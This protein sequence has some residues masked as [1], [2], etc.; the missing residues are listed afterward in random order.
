MKSYIAKV[1]FASDDKRRVLETLALNRDAWNECSKKLFV[2][3]T[4]SLK[5][6]HRLNY[7]T[8]RAK[9]QALP[10]QIVIKAEQD[11]L[12]AYRSIR[13]N[14]VKLNA[15]AIKKRLAYRLDAR[16]YSLRNDTVRLTAT[17]GK[18]VVG[19]VKLYPRL[20][21]AMTL[22]V[23]DPIIFAKNN[24]IFLTIPCKTPNPPIV[25]NFAIGV[26]LGIKRAIA[27]SEGVFVSRKSLNRRLRKLSF[28]KRK[29]QS[30]KSRSAKRKLKHLSRKHFNMSRD[31]THCCVNRVLAT[32]ANTIAIEWLKTIK[33]KS[34]GR[35]MNR[36]LWQW[37][38]GDFRRILEYKALALGKRVTMVKAAFTSQRDWRGLQEG[39]RKGRRYY[40]SDGIVFDAD[41]NAA[42]NIARL[43]KIPISHRKV[44]DG[45]AQVSE[46]NVRVF[47]HADKPAVLTA[48]S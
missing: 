40:A 4:L 38:A 15:P 23:G 26:D 28:K 3:K 6:V 1:E 19:K 47:I 35:D 21:S 34:R 5:N 27:T 24:E 37:A 18:R 44:L 30:L 33:L 13:S 32:Q 29:L 16:I 45:Q 17:G 12:A 20:I 36:R 43:S 2:T 11:C 25:E 48:G 39:K 46:P 22:G 31:F 14:K 10:S 7:S 9:I 41:W 8:I 42:M